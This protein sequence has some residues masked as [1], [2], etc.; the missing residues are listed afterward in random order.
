MKKTLMLV[1]NLAVVCLASSGNQAQSFAASPHQSR[2]A[3]SVAITPGVVTLG[4]GYRTGQV[5][6]LYNQDGSRWQSFSLKED[7]AALPKGL[8]PF[9]LHPDYYL[10]VFRCVGRKD[11]RYEVVVNEA[12]GATKYVRADDTRFRYQSWTQHLLS[13]F[14]VDI[15]PARNPLKAQPASASQTL[16]YNRDEFYHPH[17]VH[18]NWLQVKWGTEGSWQYGWVEWKRNGRLAVEL[19]YFA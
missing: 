6:S 7:G 8:A 9:A 14:S 19:F 4:T 13:A 3:S 2:S 15:N 11:G 18:G 16:P 12:T 5:L 1:L 10:V 17:K